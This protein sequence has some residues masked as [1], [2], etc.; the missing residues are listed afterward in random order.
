MCARPAKN[1]REQRSAVDFLGL[2]FYRGRSRKA[3]AVPKVKASGRRLRSKPTCVTAWLRATRNWARRTAIWQ[4]FGAKDRGHVRYHG[5]SFNS[6]ALAIFVRPAT[7]ILYKWLN[8]CSQRRLFN[9][10]TFGQFNAAHPLPRSPIYHSL[11]ERGA[12]A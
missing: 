10:E 1:G 4:A 9:W 6:G 11:F 12:V 2:T 5:L 8:R 7:R 3:H